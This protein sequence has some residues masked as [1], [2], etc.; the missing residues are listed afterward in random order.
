M[1]I[2]SGK[3]FKKY[4]IRFAFLVVGLCVLIFSL[5]WLHFEQILL[6]PLMAGV[7]IPAEY[8]DI[9]V[10][11]GGGMRRDAGVKIGFSTN[12][13][14]DQAV[15]LY[16]VKPRPILVSDGSLYRKSPAVPLV[17]KYLTDQGVKLDNIIID[18]DSQTTVDNVEKTIEISNKRGLKEII[19]CTSPYHQKRSQILLE[20]AYSVNFMI[21]V[22]TESEVF[23][24]E[25]F[26]KWLRSMNL[27]LH[28]YLAITV[29]SIANW[30]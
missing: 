5:F 21:A 7:S 12:E 16:R 20:Q 11:F 10:V 17:I 14:L 1:L 24:T 22:S 4:A 23:K 30:F 18:G 3:K 6:Q 13:R 8:G 19:I 28:E 26:G 25:S 29:I 27:I 2:S 9:I 15:S